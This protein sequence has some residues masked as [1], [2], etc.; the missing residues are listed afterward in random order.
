MNVYD[1]LQLNNPKSKQEKLEPKYQLD[2]VL[3]LNKEMVNEDLEVRLESILF[4]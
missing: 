3:I 2:F 4:I 1:N